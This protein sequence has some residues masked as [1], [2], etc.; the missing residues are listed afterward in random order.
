MSKDKETIIQNV[1]C[2]GCTAS[3][4]SIIC[5]V[6]ENLLTRCEGCGCCSL[7][8]LVTPPKVKTKKQM[9]GVT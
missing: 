7:L 8:A 6:N 9:A 1:F 3:K 5:Y 4:M 2:K